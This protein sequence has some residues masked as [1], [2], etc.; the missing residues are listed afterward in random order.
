AVAAGAEVAFF[1]LNVKDINYLKTKEQPGS[2]QAI[3]L[4]DNPEVLLS[5]LRASKYT[6]AVAIIIAANYMTHIFL[7]PS[8]H[9]WLAFLLNLVGIT[10]LLLLFGEILPKVYARQNNVRLA[11]FSA[12]IVKVMFGFFRPAASFLTD[13]NEYSDKKKARKKILDM[14]SRE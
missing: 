8:E 1:T 10:F 2:R 7:P 4:L 13:S 9:P 12:P 11:L 14:D 3:Q 6:L 5:T